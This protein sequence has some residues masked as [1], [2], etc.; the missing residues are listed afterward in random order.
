MLNL[1]YTI[2][3]QL[4]NK[5]NQPL[6]NLRIEA[7]DKD[8]LVNDFI[9]E[10]ITDLDG[11]FEISFTQAH[12]REL[13]F[14]NKPDLYFKIYQ[15]DKMIH[16]TENS[17]L[18]N[19]DNDQKKLE[20]VIHG[21]LT[22]PLEQIKLQSLNTVSGKVSD[23]NGQPLANLKVVI[24]DVDMRN[25]E[26]LV[27]TFTDKQG[28]FELSWTL[29]QLNGRGK[30]GADIGIKVF[31]KEKN[32]ELFKSGM[33]DVRF[34]A[35]KKEEFN[36]TISQTI[37]TEVIEFDFLIKEVTSLTRNIAT[38]DLQENN[39]HQDITFLSKELGLATGKIE[40][41]VVAHRL[42][43]RSKIDAGF[44]YALLRKNTL[45]NKNFTKNLSTRLFIG[46]HDEEKT[47]LYDAALA[48]VNKIEADIK[49]AYDEKIVSVDV[50]EKLK[51]NI[52]LL[53]HYRQE[54]E[55][56]YQ[57]EHPKKVIDLLAS[58]FEP[59]KL[60]EAQLLFQENKNDLK[61]FINK[62]TDASFFVSKDKEADA[63]ITLTLSKLF[64]FGNEVIP[65]II[66]AKD[67]KNPED[68][69]RLAKLNKTAWVN[70][71]SSANPA[72]EDKQLISTYSSAIVRK[73]E[74]EY[75]TMA[76]AAQLEREER[77][78]Y[79][80][81]D[82][83]VS[84]FSKHE[85]FDLHKHNV[86]LYLK[87]KNVDEKDSEFIRDE[88][89]SVQRIF[90]LIPHYG[91]TN[92]LR[93]EKIHSAQGIVAIGETRFTKEIAQKIGLTEKEAGN[94]FRTAETKHTAA[95][96]LLGDLQDSVSVN[97]IAS[98]ET[99]SLALKIEA[100]TKDF[101]NLKS[102]FKLVDTCECEHCRSVYSPAAYL[103][104]ILHFL[105]YKTVPT[106]DAKKILF[107]RRPD[108]GEIDLSCANSNTPVKY[109]D[110]VCELLENAVA[111]DPGIEFTGNLAEGTNSLI[112]KISTGLLTTLQNAGLPVTPNALIYHSESGNSE[113]S[114]HYLRDTKLVCKITNTANSP[115][116]VFRLRQTLSSAE[117]LDA[118]PEYVNEAA[119]IKLLEKSFA[120]GL[121]FDLHHTEAKAYFNRFNV[122]RADLMRDFQSGGKV[123][124][125]LD[126]NIAAERLGLTH[127]ELNIIVSPPTTNDNAAQQAFWNVPDPETVLEYMKRVDHFLNKT[128]LRFKEL[129]LL[130]KLEFID[131]NK[132][133]FI[134]HNNLTCNTEEKEIANLDLAA[135]DRI[136]RFLR[137]QKKTGWKFEVINAILSQTNLGNN[138]LDAKDDN[139][140][141][142][143]NGN[144]C[145][146]KAA[147]LKE[148]S[149]KTGIKI[150]ELIGCFGT[151]P[152]AL[153]NDEL[154][155]PLYHQIFLNK[156][157]SGIINE[158]F[159]PE[160]LDNP[161]MLTGHADYLATCLQLKQTELEFIIPLLK[162]TKLSFSN[163]SYL[164]CASRLI[165]K[166]NLTPEDFAIL[167][168]MSGIE[169]TQSPQNILDFIKVT[170][171]FKTSPLKAAD[172]NFIF[173]SETTV[174]NEREIRDE[175]ITEL[176][177]K[178]KEDAEKFVREQKSKYDKNL[179]SQ[180]QKETLQKELLKLNN[181]G[182]SDPKIISQFVD[183]NWN[184]KWTDD[185]EV[186]HTGSSVDQ[187]KN[188]LTTKLDG[189]IN[190]PPII[191]F[192]NQI[193]IAHNK[194]LNA[195]NDLTGSKVAMETAQTAVK[196]AVTPVEIATAESLLTEAESL[197]A[198]S[199]VAYNQA[200]AEL[201]N[202]KR[203]F[204]KT[205]LNA[206][207]EYQAANEKTKILEDLLATGFQTD[208]GIIDKVLKYAKFNQQ[209][210]IS[211][212][213]ADD[214][215][216][217]T[218][219][220]YAAI[221]LVHKMLLL[222]NAFELGTVDLKWFLEN[223]AKL[224]WLE[225]DGIPFNAEKND[226]KLGKYLAFAKIVS[227]SKQY[228]A[229]V[230]PVDADK[231]IS[232]L[233][234]EEMLLP[235]SITTKDE[236]IQALAY[237]TGYLKD[238]LKAIDAH[239]FP[240]TEL[241]IYRDLN[242]WD[243]VFKCA[244]TLRK[245][246]ASVTQVKKY[247]VPVLTSNVVNDLRATLKS[248]Y[249]ES[250]WLRTLKEIM[251]TIRPQKRDAL[252]TYLLATNPGIKDK[253]DLYEY[254]LVDVEMEACMPSSRIVLAHNSI[255]L[256]VQRCLMGLEPSV[257][258]NVEEDPN[259]NQW[260]WMKNYR[261]WEA[262]RKV[263]LYPENWYDVTLSDDK[264]YLLTEFINEI[265][266]NEL[267][268]DTAEEA[269]KK[270]LEKLD[271]IA[272]LEVM[273]TWYDV[274][275]RQMHVFARTKG[276]DPS[277][278]YYRRLENENDWS[279]WEKVEL[280]ITGDHLIAFKRNNR[281]CLAWPVFSDEAKPDQ[282]S[283]I[284]KITETII[285]NDKPE[286]RLKIQL[287]VS[288]YTN[289]NWQ[290]KRVSKDAI[291]APSEYSK[292]DDDFKRDIYYLRYFSWPK[293]N[294]LPLTQVIS[295]VIGIFK[296]EN[297]GEFPHQKLSGVFNLAGCKG[298]PELLYTGNGQSFMPNFLP[299]FE[300]T[301]LVNQRFL[302]QNQMPSDS[303]TVRNGINIF[304][305]APDANL[306]LN[307][308]PGN[309]SIS[310]PHQFTGIDLLSL[311]LQFLP[312][313]LYKSKSN[314]QEEAM[315][316]TVGM[317]YRFEIPSGTLLPYFKEDS[318]HAYVIIPGFYKKM[319]ESADGYTLND[320][321]KRTASNVFQLIDDLITFVNKITKPFRAIP[322]SDTNARIN[323]ITNH[324][325]FQNLNIELSKYN[326]DFIYNILTKNSDDIVL[327]EL[328]KKI[329][330]TDG[331]VYGEQ[332]KNMYHPLVCFL[333]SL[334]YQD[335]IPALM[336]RTTQLKETEF[337]FEAHYKPNP[338][339][340]PKSF[341][342]NSNGS[343]TPS[344]PIEDIDFNNDGSYSA[345]N[346][347]LFF[348]VPLHIAS[349]LTKNQ[350]YE[351]ALTWFHY[352]FN[353]TGALIGAGTQKYWI[354]KPFYLNQ[355]ADYEAQ[356]IDALLYGKGLSTKQISDLELA[357]SKWRNNPFRPDVVAR[358]RPV[359]YQK[360]LLMKYLDNLT[361]WGDYLFRQDTMES[362]AQAT[363]MYI[364]ADKLLGPKPRTI[365]P[366]VKA[367]YET[368]NQ[369]ESKLNNFGNA[370]IELE[371]ILPDLTVL[372]EKGSELPPPPVTL[373]M[374]Y[375]CIPPN[376][377]MEEYWNRIADRLFKIRH[378][379]NI[380]GV[381]RSLAL[382]APPI[383][384]G[385]LVRAAASGL[386]IS[387]VLAGLNAPTP[388]YRFNVLSQKATELAQEVRG[389]GNSLLQ[390]LEKKDAEALTLL[391]SELES[392]LLNATKDIKKLQINES[393]EQIEV[394][395][396]TK[397]VTEERQSYY[398]QIKKIIPNEQLNMDL[399]D[400][401]QNYQLL[402][403]SSLTLGGAFALLPQTTIGAAGFGGSPTATL[404]WGG[405]NLSSAAKSAADVLNIFGSMASFEATRA[406]T[407]AGYDRRFDD[408]KLQELLAIK[409]LDSINKQISAAEIR[410]EIAE[411]DLKN[412]E[413]QIDNAKKT[414]E[415]MRSKYT[416][417][418]LYEWMIGQISSVYFKSYQLAHDF[419]KKAERCYRFELGND[420]AFISYGYWDS[421]KKGLQ[422]A[423]NLIHDIKRMEASYL[424]KNKREY[425]ITKHVSIAQLD[426]FALVM[427]RTTGVCDF[428]IPEVLYDMDYPGQYFRRLKSV[429][430]SLPCIA[431]P[432]TSVSAKLSLINNRFRKI[433]D[434]TGSDYNEDSGNDNR[435]TYNIGAIQSIA[436][437]NAQ[438][439]SGV[440]ELNFRDERYLP[441]E[442][443]G[444]I[445]SW[446]LELPSEIKQFDYN[447][448]SDVVLHVKYT[449]REGGSGLKTAANEALK[450][451]LDVIKQGLGQNGLHV[452]LNL[453]QDFSNEWHLLKKNIEVNITIDKTRLPYMVQFFDDIKI[454]NV[455]FIAKIKKEDSFK[456]N[457]NSED[458]M[459]NKVNNLIIYKGTVQ[460]VK[461]NIPFKLSL[462][463]SNSSILEELFMVVN[464]SIK[465]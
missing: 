51:R 91:K 25:W 374:L 390:A 34:N 382:F 261:V 240:T 60:A 430:L 242:N 303:L 146:I 450:D 37:P 415:F 157:K 307:Q 48:D 421:M 330:T 464:Y 299:D 302:E 408:W 326:L 294:D 417:K 346:W 73:F 312:G 414:D 188:Y 78:L 123:R 103:V 81:Q 142:I 356:R 97:D 47:L 116:K 372:P 190:V 441:F 5:T 371:N 448:I 431:G 218:T 87:E 369:L 224:G 229:V 90:K 406:A 53:S 268:N 179:S 334:L 238:D 20:I 446:R 118:S 208:L 95:V 319:D 216:N 195:N 72:I 284:P 15:G 198:N 126:E 169:I 404:K 217:D 459:F 362:I 428:D 23:A 75:P 108:L 66:K 313:L 310:F 419:A 449:A 368:Y 257:I 251:D 17:E 405:F 155:K 104:E 445:S 384:P 232:L 7:W 340:V 342:K 173:D 364:M 197:V 280:D 67:I 32:T 409:E 295:E 76:F 288:E 291:F 243:L 254:F 270:Y 260:K 83:I 423:D 265:Q 186:A 378:C 300:D 8:L 128:G 289:K 130:L 110:L 24:Y 395:N 182:E 249:D 228:P 153:Y 6:S 231:L 222:I 64:G 209:S 354:T 58:V 134:K 402:A 358:F 38:A 279:P 401:A 41:L 89:K 167:I 80:N 263:F 204:I 379:Q 292:N 347:D 143:T 1:N 236:F 99:K 436:T 225:L 276:G 42:Q 49:I 100:V 26:A 309:F 237:L 152:H 373:S 69:R 30:K 363:Q 166:L 201:E 463:E 63:K 206:I 322:V 367:P 161:E 345:Y 59:G 22:T 46:I 70:E 245:L 230:N 101:P 456:M 98:F 316:H 391:R 271:T 434:L 235:G 262:N 250:T 311:L 10:A 35:G 239:L 194:T 226:I 55:D 211:I 324:P 357:I 320:S 424:D 86:D 168:S 162:D 43:D 380:D 333:R 433:T 88:L 348:R 122:N 440:F 170:E 304:D 366:T 457:I 455:V 339:V 175:K 137:L 296:R 394:L 184:F 180:E 192:L 145:L 399:L 68:I 273:A 442:N 439:D 62:I 148:I 210:L 159:L 277:I 355:D 120:F 267:T 396:R 102:L 275:T 223:N 205:I 318:N 278:Y 385:M 341:Y 454:E 113:K 337:N 349:S 109:I 144:E 174:L 164:Y 317:Q 199:L 338:K 308:T 283:I 124:V 359:A 422:S 298:Y 154:S 375:F 323:I 158:A 139:S 106:G 293:I 412:H 258:A 52:D 94:I 427:L 426:P 397:K 227:Y 305:T 429:S 365:P 29:E 132:N 389:L 388:Y 460:D 185:S 328:V 247:I 171:D 131:L 127:A 61:A 77:P 71:I 301:F 360:A 207:A 27:H 393:K 214:I 331:L 329:K 411:T 3:G 246:G 133:L 2:S 50:T 125:P 39:D 451:Q 400:K 416:N 315:Y 183:G 377:K 74:N 266:Q 350:R 281:L 196:I 193:N 407:L 444:A 40:H 96:L 14:D 244:E 269:L 443:T 31:T 56:Y 112:G 129:D 437:S 187:A 403:Q 336:K 376:E 200:T 202:I 327:N 149:E 352:M 114:P 191:D 93:E 13:F 272:F 425:E 18:W 16:S 285:K 140:N 147:Q 12:Y 453:K 105:K 44:F 259:W 286:K 221:R 432:Y 165:K 462:T 387:S 287:A 9:G 92:A 212:L 234:L 111:Q 413:L 241:T 381:E 181:V 306:I 213:L 410:K 233:T 4:L 121:P 465:K 370:L 85:D 79:R 383:D 138:K 151:I 282:E 420:E 398:S 150:D 325:D 386:D 178:L 252:I 332:F 141:G 215:S 84:F 28:K 219:K 256:F 253:N 392:K 115:Y 45:L 248:R 65:Q 119:Y 189:L 156:A 343:S 82:K 117:E 438:N 447:T 264:T 135:L 435:F 36:I 136:H 21:D 54:A 160:N 33:E 353:P 314:S 11:R 458:V 351:E 335:G 172:L 19:I 255:Q 418:E 297:K 344:Y 203:D 461:L 57:N 290:P 452:A 220:K 177:S 176:L 361:E 163:L 321:D 107:D 274:P